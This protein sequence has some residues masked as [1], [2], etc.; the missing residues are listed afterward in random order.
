MKSGGCKNYSD[1]IS[2][3]KSPRNWNG[4]KSSPR[5]CASPRLQGVNCGNTS[6]KDSLSGRC[7]RKT[8]TR[9]GIFCVTLR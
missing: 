5:L 9:Q 2:S 8:R 1:L 6:D 3:Y 7:N 4:L